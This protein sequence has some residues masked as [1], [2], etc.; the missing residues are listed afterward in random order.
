MM[1][2]QCKN[3]FW[4]DTLFHYRH[5]TKQAHFLDVNNPHIEVCVDGLAIQNDERTQVSRVKKGE[6]EISDYCASVITRPI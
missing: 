5:H 3:N 6:G 4:N 1:P 2:Q